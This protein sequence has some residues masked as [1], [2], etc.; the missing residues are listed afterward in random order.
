MMGCFQT[1]AEEIRRYDGF[2]EKFI[3]DAILAVFGAPVAHEDD[4]ERAVHA[5][6]G[7]QARLQQLRTSVGAST[8]GALTMRIGINTGLVVAGTVGEGNDYGVIG[9]TVNVAKRLQQVGA[10]GKV[11]VSEETYRVVRKS[12]DCRSLGDLALKGKT[13]PIHTFEVVGPHVR[14]QDVPSEVEFLRIP[15][16]GRDDE[17]RQ[18]MEFVARACKGK[19]QVVSL[20]GE[21]GVGKSRLVT[22]LLHRLDTKGDLKHL[23][24]YQATCSGFGSKAYHV[25]INFFRAC[26]SLTA[27]DSAAQ[28]K[29]KIVAFLQAIGAPTESIVPVIEKLLGF[30]EGERNTEHLDP[31]QF[32]RQLFLAV[33]E[34][35]QRQCRQHPVMLVVEDFQWADAASVE[36]LRSLVDRVADRP[37]LLLLV[38]RPAPQVEVVYSAKVDMEQQ[39]VFLIDKAG[40]IRYV[41]TTGS[42]GG[43]PS[44]AEYVRQLNELQ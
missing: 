24:L 36:L 41:H 21:A 17:L 28:A 37:L 16:I 11:T 18:M 23:V 34:I 27:E 20:I 43:L 38:T 22:E 10:P 29:T 31:E 30:V 12:F 44:N 8:A 26:F 42:L 7:M 35:C 14:G 39:A 1:L 5:A 33:R 9:D 15:L 25:L 13:D 3:G 2:I 32:K 40:V 6:L 19:P 4:A